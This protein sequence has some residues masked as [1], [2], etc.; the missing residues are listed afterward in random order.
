[1]MNKILTVI[2]AITQILDG[3]LTYLGTSKLGSSGEGNALIR[4][5]M[6]M[7]GIPLSLI[8]VKGSA[9][10]LVYFFYKQCSAKFW[11]PLMTAWLI[12]FYVLV[13]IIPWCVVLNS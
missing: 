1:M 9:L 2:F 10:V 6:D 12:S 8:F 7:M 11:Y 13:A 3:A 5:L 4:T